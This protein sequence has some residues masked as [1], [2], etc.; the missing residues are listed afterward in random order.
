MSNLK[1]KLVV[2][3]PT[4]DALMRAKR[5]QVPGVDIS[6]VHADTDK[7]QVS[8]FMNRDFLAQPRA[9]IYGFLTGD[10]SVVLGGLKKI[11]NA[12]GD[13]KT[14]GAVYSDKL[15]VKDEGVTI[16]QFYPPFEVDSK[17]ICNP[18][19]FVNGGITNPLFS[20]QLNYLR[21]FDA[22]RKIGQAACIIHIPSFLVRSRF[23]PGN[24]D[25]ELKHVWTTS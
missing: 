22:L 12:F 3:N 25:E 6:V 20:E 10:D 11:V 4:P 17:F 9:D 19:I 7:D 24:I 8:T 16:P 23:E 21:F 13:R 1:L 5:E 15:L 18:T 2:A 14:V